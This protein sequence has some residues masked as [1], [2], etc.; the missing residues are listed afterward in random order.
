MSAAP[1]RPGPAYAVGL[2][3]TTT[4]DHGIETYLAR[5]DATLAPFGGRFLVH[6]GAVEA[7]EGQWTS[8]LVVIRFPDMAAARAWYHSP[9]YREILPLRTRRVKGAVALVE[10]VAE[11]H[12]AGDILDALRATTMV[13]QA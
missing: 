4:V 2:L 7:L 9:A 3:R 11:G 1:A 13:R 12:R 8:D 10:G 6:G 5:I